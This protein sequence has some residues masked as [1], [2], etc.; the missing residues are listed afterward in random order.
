V[1]G[2]VWPAV[3]DTGFNGDLELPDHLRPHVNARFRGTCL[4]VLAGG[5]SVLEDVFVVDFPF[6]GRTVV[7]A[8]TFVPHGPIL[9]GTSLLQSYRL[10]IDFVA[11]TVVL[12]R[13]V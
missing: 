7:V 8:A 3:V 9:I 6:D 1:A 2:Q 11:R 13:V 10:T 5:Q 4:S 12:E